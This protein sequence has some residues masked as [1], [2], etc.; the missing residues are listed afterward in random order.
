M[1]W[2][3]MKVNR[4]TNHIWTSGFSELAFGI[5]YVNDIDI[6]VQRKKE[7]GPNVLRKAHIKIEME[8][9][10]REDKN[11]KYKKTNFD[12]SVAQLIY[13]CFIFSVLIVTCQRFFESDLV[14]ML[15]VP[16]VHKYYIKVTKNVRQNATNVH[17]T[18]SICNRIIS[19]G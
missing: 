3:V 10:S 7:I 8:I 9:A 17:I 19:N 14:H 15:P 2:T 13:I 6:C 5:H 11:L 18:H 12:S 1:Y 16:C 4:I